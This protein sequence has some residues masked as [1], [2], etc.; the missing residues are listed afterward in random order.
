MEVFVWKLHSDRDVVSEMYVNKHKVTLSIKNL[1]LSHLNQYF[2][3]PAMFYLIPWK[4][5]NCTL[6]K[7][8][9]FS[10]TGVQNTNLIA[11]PIWKIK[12]LKLL[13]FHLF[14]VCFYQTSKMH[15]IGGSVGQITFS[16]SNFSHTSRV[17]LRV[18]NSK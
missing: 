16:H 8:F 11:G 7:I 14:K 1:F 5:Y 2:Q 12:G 9:C 15:L 10:K 3:K 17:R 13:F 18:Q 6:K 4:C